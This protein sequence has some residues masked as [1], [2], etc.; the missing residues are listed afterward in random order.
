MYKFLITGGL[1]FVG[2]EIVRQLVKTQQVFIVDS[3]N[4][5][6][7]DIEDIHNVPCHEIDITDKSNLEILF[8]QVKPDFVIHL[9]AIHFIPECNEFPN[10]T[11]KINVEGTQ[12]LLDLSEKYNVKHFVM[13]SSGAVYSDSPDALNELNSNIEPVDIYGF[14]K[15]FCENLANLKSK[16]N[17]LPITMVRLFNV[18]GPRETNPHIIPEII[19]QLRNSN[20]LK[21]GTISTY[22]D[23]VYTEDVAQIFIKLSFNIPLDNYRV[24]NLGSGKA[25]TIQNLIEIISGIL[26]RDI[27]I[28]IDPN[29]IR[30]VDKLVQVADNSYLLSL[31]PDFKFR[32]FKKGIEDLLI[33]EKLL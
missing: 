28:N 20:N 12:N 29:R 25:Y 11:L 1:G 6:A 14:S 5:I 27:N 33:Y 8:N 15:L 30:K 10:R 31:F 4:R 3:K 2:N 23:F 19:L 22:R 21:L 13:A 16:N 24:I 32:E 9:A 26:S 17:L 7:P 18:Y